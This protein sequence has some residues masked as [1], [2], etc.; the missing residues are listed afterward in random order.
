M[1]SVKKS[2]KEERYEKNIERVVC[3]AMAN[4]DRCKYKDLE[5]AKMRLGIRKDDHR[6]DVDINYIIGV[7]CS[8]DQQKEK[9][10]G[11]IV[12]KEGISSSST[13]CESPVR[14]ENEFRCFCGKS[15]KE[16]EHICCT[17]FDEINTSAF[18]EPAERKRTIKRLIP[19]PEDMIGVEHNPL[20]ERKARIFVKKEFFERF[21]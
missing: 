9:E 19:V 12:K 8:Q 3:V 10:C 15:L 2:K 11:V 6:Y 20:A 13:E 16:G 7:R 17:C 1:V 14:I 5:D 21:K 18:D 4:P